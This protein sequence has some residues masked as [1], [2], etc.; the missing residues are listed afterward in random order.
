M[1]LQKIK[2]ILSIRQKSYLK[3]KT[4]FKIFSYKNRYALHSY[5]SCMHASLLYSILIGK[6]KSQHNSDT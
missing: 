1:F 4:K 6:I 2:V 3:L 5:N